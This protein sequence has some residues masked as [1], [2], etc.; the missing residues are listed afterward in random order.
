MSRSFIRKIPGVVAI[1]H[2]SGRPSLGTKSHGSISRVRALHAREIPRR[3]IYRLAALEQQ[4]TGHG[5]MRRKGISI[6][7][8]EEPIDV[9]SIALAPFVPTTSPRVSRWD[10]AVCLAGS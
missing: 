7:A 1:S 3:A 10:P 4:D 2:E 6:I 9:R 8:R 5:K